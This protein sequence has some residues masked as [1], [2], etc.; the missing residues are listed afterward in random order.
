VREQYYNGAN[1]IILHR[2]PEPRI[3]QI[4]VSQPPTPTPQPPQPPNTTHNIT[5]GFSVDSLH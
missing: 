5:N 1:P 2:V 4:Q 3:P